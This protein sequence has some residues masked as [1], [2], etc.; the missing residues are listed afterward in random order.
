[1]LISISPKVA[2]KTKI[3]TTL[4]RGTFH[5]EERVNLPTVHKHPKY[6]CLYKKYM[7]TELQNA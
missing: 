6:V 7:I 5:N 1:M 3:I 4:E 2:F